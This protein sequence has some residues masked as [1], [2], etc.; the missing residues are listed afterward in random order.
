MVN[1]ASKVFGCN[2]LRKE[3]LSFFPKRCLHCHKKMNKTY[4]DSNVKYYWK[5]DWSKSENVMMPGYCN[6]CVFYVF[7]YH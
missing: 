3:I 4:K 7:E 5:E 2:D 6:W 1:P